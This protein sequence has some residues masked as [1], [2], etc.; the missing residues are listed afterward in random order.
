MKWALGNAESRKRAAWLAMSAVFAMTVAWL[1]RPA[2]AQSV[3]ERDLQVLARAVGFM[4]PELP[5]EATAAIAFNTNDPSSRRDAEAI[6]NRFGGGLRSG[7]VLLRPRLVPRGN[8]AAEPFSVV[9]AASGAN[10]PEVQAATRA[11]HALCVTSDLSAVRAGLC[12]MSIQ[13]GPR[14]EVVTSVNVVENLV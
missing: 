2:A 4:R 8:L 10:G 9:I 13:S 12:T 7:G 5:A 11:A 1:P 14:V 3:S 6:A